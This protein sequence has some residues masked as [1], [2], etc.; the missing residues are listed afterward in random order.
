[1]NDPEDQFTVSDVL[2]SE[3]PVI[4]TVKDLQVESH[5]DEEVLIEYTLANPIPFK[6]VVE[7]VVNDEKVHLTKEDLALSNTKIENWITQQNKWLAVVLIASIIGILS[8]ILGMV[9]VMKWFSIKNTVTT[10]NTSVSKVTKQPTGTITLLNTIRGVQSTDLN[11]CQKNYIIK[12]GISWH[13][14]LILV[15]YEVIILIVIVLVVKLVKHIH[16]LCHF[17]NL[18]MP[19]S[20]VKQNC[21]PIKMLGNKSDIYLELHSINNI[22]SIRQYIGTTMVYPTQFSMNEKLTKDDMEYHSSVLYNEINF[23]WSKIE[24]RYQNE[25][26]FFPST[27][28]VPLHGKF[29]TRKLLACLDPQY[30]IV[31]QCQKIV[32]VL[33]EHDKVLKE[34]TYSIECNINYSHNDII[35][36]LIHVQ[37]DAIL[38]NK[39]A[40]KSVPSDQKVNNDQ[41]QN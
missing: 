35:E 9:M 18:Q 41:N 29:K 38:S 13:E 39:G 6:D 26:I 30:R 8:F 12:I 22:S 19:D 20:Y 21:C 15:L 24:F 10:I 33:N 31:I 34:L 4:L 32:H 25:P 16:R 14:I 11:E 3:N 1:M 36:E 17:N 2:L 28:Q 37:T 7:C 23:D 40:C 27:I 5:E